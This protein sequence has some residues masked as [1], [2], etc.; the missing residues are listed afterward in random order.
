MSQRAPYLDAAAALLMLLFA[1]C[2][3]SSS[4]APITNSPSSERFCADAPASGAPTLP[5]TLSATPGF[6]DFS[7]AVTD[8][9]GKPLVGLTQSDF[10]ASTS[11]GPLP[12][13][14]FKESPAVPVTLGILIDTSG[15]MEPKLPVV[16]GVM[17]NFVARISPCDEFFLFAF[18]SRPF[19]LQPLTINHYLVLSRLELLHAFGQTSL[20]DSILDGLLMVQHGHYTRKALL[21]L[22]DGMDNTSQATLK[23]VTAVARQRG[24]PIYVIG[25]GDPDPHGMLHSAFAG[26]DSKNL[27][28]KALNQLA[29]AAGGQAFI[30]SIQGNGL[31]D[32]V[33]S[34]EAHFNPAY[35]IGLVMPAAGTSSTPPP[36]TVASTPPPAEPASTSP[37]SS[38]SATAPPSA[39]AATQPLRLTVPGHPDAVVTTQI[40]NVNP[41]PPPNFTSSTLRVIPHGL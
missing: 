33:A 3:T 21:V 28:V 17:T 37:P 31:A 36:A 32:A 39:S 1:S 18:S 4:T 25:I 9:N 27:D 5:Q 16:N 11:A 41:S 20:Y 34:I 13:A 12:I 2:A 26:N 6:T 10:S 8:P 30:V 38:G 35:T 29:D 19:M 15:S 7:A 23:Q 14:W 40:I 22:T 24:V